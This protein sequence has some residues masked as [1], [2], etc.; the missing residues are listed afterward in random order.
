MHF[1][2]LC[3]LCLPASDTS[4]E[5]RPEA[6]SVNYMPGRRDM[7]TIFFYSLICIVVHAVIQEYIL[8]VSDY[9]SST[10]SHLV[11]PWALHQI[12]RWAFGW[13][14]I[15]KDFLSLPHWFDLFIVKLKVFMFSTVNHTTALIST[16]FMTEFEVFIGNL[17]RY[18]FPQKHAKSKMAAIYMAMHQQ[19]YN[20][21]HTSYFSI[22][23]RSLRNIT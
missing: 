22:Q 23:S 8:D 3:L 17:Q 18:P 13:L 6:S 12:D 9:I 4:E 16:C 7:F 1:N 2:T 21:Y 5:P 20:I 14:V 11:L 19:V 10:I 15:E